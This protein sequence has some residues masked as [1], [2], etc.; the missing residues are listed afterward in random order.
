MHPQ[1]EAI[2]REF[3]AAEQRLLRLAGSLPGHWWVR[4]PDP[5][6]WSVAECVAHLNLSAEA[7]LPVIQAGLDRAR[8]I[9]GPPPRRY[10]RDPVG[11]LL[12]RTMGPPVRFRVRTTAG[13]L[14]PAP[15]SAEGLVEAFSSLQTR[16]QDA[17]RAADGLPLG[18]VRIVSPF[19]PRVRY[20]LYSCLTILPRHQ[21]RHLWQAER[22]LE[23][24]R[25]GG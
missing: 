6:R 25:S 5:S 12:W 11:W 21:H 3:T 13:F 9:G 17:L 7:Y 1:L 2:A 16:Q 22:V 4:R 18:R 24:L 15:D 23:E 20:N 10:R 19:D 14:P 8:R